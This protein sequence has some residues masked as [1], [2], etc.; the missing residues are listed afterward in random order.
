M[1]QKEWIFRPIEERYVAT[2]RQKFGLN[3]FLARFLAARAIPLEDVPAFLSPKIR[4]LLP[5][6][7]RLLDLSKAAVRTAQALKKGENV[8][9]YGD[10]DVDGATSVAQLLRYFEALG[11]PADFYVPDR[12]SEGYG[13]NL[14]AV[15]TIAKRGT[16]LLIMVDCGTGSVAEVERAQALGMDTIVLDHHVAGP[17]LPPAIA[18]VNA[19][20]LDQPSVPHIQDLCSAGLVFLFLVELQRQLRTLWPEKSKEAPNLIEFCDFVALGTVCD[21]M[22]LLG[23]N[24]AFVQR[25]LE[26]L[27]QRNNC[28]LRALMDVA[29]VADRPTAYHL[30]FVLGPRM[31][32]GG[33]VGTSR[34]GTELLT[35][36]DDL[37]AKELAQL[38]DRLNAERQE[39]ERQTIDEATRQIETQRLA[40]QPVL[41]VG[42]ENW[43]PGVIGIA[44][45]R[46]KESFARPVFVAAFQGDEAKGSARSVEGFDIGTLIHQA[47]QKGLLKGGGGHAMAGGFTIEKAKFEAFRSFLNDQA[48]EF[49]TSYRPALTIDGELSLRGA[50]V[51]L[52]QELVLL[53]PFG[54]GNPRPYFCFRHVRVRSSR[55]VGQGHLQCILE[56]GHGGSL[57]AIAF[58]CQETQLGTLLSIYDHRPISVVGTLNLNTW[59]NRVNVQMVIEDARPEDEYLEKKFS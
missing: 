46:L 21:V 19:F 39:L 8:T 45:S 16:T 48:H 28:G 24:R 32:A 10:Y 30:G 43:H 13:V 2:I 9:I 5:D 23:L 15:E 18:V 54:T 14:S 7:S 31:N 50:T 55:P 56:D 33:R 6:P 4:D 58:R 27:A 37:R 22:P 34:L 49:M 25:G 38:L 51:E 44:A 17:R 57:R 3:D 1:T 47:L 42:A 52:L 53:E 12:L 59:Q 41:L 36:S 26:V 11:Q 20:R 35:T 29:S 40:D